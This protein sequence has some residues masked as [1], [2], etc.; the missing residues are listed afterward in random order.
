VQKKTFLDLR[1][2]L[3]R[4]INRWRAELMVYNHVPCD[5]ERCK[6]VFFAKKRLD[7]NN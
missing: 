4:M 5:F 7:I 3:L 2:L 1:K 6:T